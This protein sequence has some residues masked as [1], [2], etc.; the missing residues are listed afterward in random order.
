[1]Y[2]QK[3]DIDNLL[4]FPNVVAVGSGYKKAK[5]MIWK[6]QRATICSVVKKLPL[7]DLKSNQVIPKIMK[8]IPTD[9]VETG[10]IKA[11]AL[12]DKHH[13]AF[14]GV[15]IGHRDITAGTFGCLVK[16]DGEDHIL[17]NNHVLANSNDGVIGDAILQ[18]GPHDGGIVDTDTIASLADFI[19]IEFTEGLPDCDIT[20]LVEWLWNWLGERLRRKHRLRAYKLQDGINYVDAA[21][22]GPVMMGIDVEKGI[23]EIGEIVGKAAAKV[24]DEVQKTGR[25][26]GYTKDE[27]LQ[28]GV[29]VNVQY[30]AGKIA[31]FADQ[32]MAGPMSAG[33][34]SG[35]AVLN[36]DKEIVGLLFAGS[37]EVTILN[38]IDYVFDKLGVTL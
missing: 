23:A 36:M 16:K 5:D 8:G 31:Q 27:I 37:D 20:K 17:S 15:S 32:L 24:G 28:E 30:G 10:V 1:M 21:I 33:G 6:G 13:P 35:S 9:V 3:K 19:P 34:D 18:P 7:S 25:T 22:A 26:T 4:S 2:L 14:G 29:T 11:L 38:P 12:T